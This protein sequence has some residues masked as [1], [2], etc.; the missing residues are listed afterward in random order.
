MRLRP[1]SEAEAYARCYGDGD[2]NVRATRVTPRTP[3]YENAVSGSLSGRPSSSDSTGA[4]RTSL[5]PTAASPQLPET[6]ALPDVLGPAS[7]PSSAASTR[8]ASRPRRRPLRQSPQRLL[9]P[10]AR[11]RLHAAPARP[12]GAGASCLGFGFGLTNA[13]LPHDPR[14]GRPPPRRLRGL[15]RAARAASPTS[16]GHARSPSSARRPT[17][18]AFGERPEL[19]LQERRLG[20]TLLF[21]L[22]ST[23]P[24]NAAVP[25][26]SGSDGSGPCAELSRRRRGCF[27][28]ASG[29]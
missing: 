2:E 3:R 27:S 17:A 28:R 12:G 21:V 22:P 15:G 14:L 5:R 11:G 20:E 16:C 24:A 13:A 18:G 7:T 4:N 9:A 10:A 6:G 26:S 19:G 25:Y 29:S 23:S 8:A 1:L